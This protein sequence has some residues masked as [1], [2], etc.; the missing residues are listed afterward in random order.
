[1][2]GLGF[3]HARR[4]LPVTRRARAQAAKLA[5]A[6]SRLATIADAIRELSSAE[7]AHAHSIRRIARASRGALAEKAAANP[8]Q[9]VIMN[10]AANAL[11]RSAGT[12]EAL[13]RVAE[14][15]ELLVTSLR[16]V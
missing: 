6:R 14:A 2:I 5:A 15:L 16:D 13:D 10:H 3:L 9:D 8:V 11:A 12:A 4:F 1:M 7:D